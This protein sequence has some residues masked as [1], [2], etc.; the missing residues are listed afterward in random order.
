MSVSDPGLWIWAALI[1]TTIGCLGLAAGGLCFL[2][3]GIT[4]LT[5]TIRQRPNRPEKR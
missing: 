1:A 4:N 5:R 2:A 3:I